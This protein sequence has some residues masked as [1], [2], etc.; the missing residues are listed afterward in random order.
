MDI[1]A[2][3]MSTAL[4]A[5]G[6]QPRSK[7]PIRLWW[8]VFFGMLPDLATFTVPACLRIWWWATGASPTLLPQANGPHIGQWATSLYNGTHS[9]VV[10]AAAFGAAWLLL[11][12]PVLEM[13]GW[14]LHI[15][16]DI[17]TH[18]E[19]FATQFLWPVSSFHVD[20]IRW[21]TGWLLASTYGA[22]VIALF[23]LWR[24]RARAGICGRNH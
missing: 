23:A 13:L 5:I 12:R 19:M 18:R 15:V 17:F 3:G 1:I 14:T 16:I 4:A 21:E 10:F 22:L 9:L 6:M 20:G 8:T 2:H 11:R 24:R 7:Q